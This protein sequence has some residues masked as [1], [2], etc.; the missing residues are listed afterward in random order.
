MTKSRKCLWCHAR[1]KPALRGAHAKY[2]CGSCRQRA[3]E[4]RKLR[5]AIECAVPLV[6]LQLL[7]KELG[8]PLDMALV[9]EALREILQEEGYIQP[10]NAPEPPKQRPLLR[11]VA[12]TGGEQNKK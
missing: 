10:S 5:A 4:K 3:Y 11:L 2:C 6:P 12:K 1:F 7:R 9:K 8:A